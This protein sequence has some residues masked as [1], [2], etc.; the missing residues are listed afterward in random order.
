MTDRAVAAPE[1]HVL[2]EL[3][4]ER[5]EVETGHVST[6]RANGGVCALGLIRFGGQFDYAANLYSFAGSAALLLASTTFR[7][8]L[9]PLMT[10]KTQSADGSQL[11]V[12]L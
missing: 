6:G 5:V 3:V 11:V 9:P 8:N 12:C 4:P 10:K 7:S 2:G 1:V